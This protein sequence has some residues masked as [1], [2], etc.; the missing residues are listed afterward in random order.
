MIRRPSPL[1]NPTLALLACL[2]LMSVAWGSTVE[3]QIELPIPQ[4]IDVTGMRRVLVGGFRASDDPSVDVDIEYIDYTR[5]LLRKRSNFEVIDVDP[6]PLPEQEVKDI[7]NNR[8]YWR[9]LGKRYSADLIIAGILDFDRTDQSGFVQED[10]I[11]PITG[12][13]IRRTRYTEREGFNLASTLYFFSG[14][15]GELLYEQRLT[16][17][18]IFPG[19]NLDGLAVLHQLAARSSPEVLG[20]LMPRTKLETRYLFTE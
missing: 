8:S 11:S 10:I 4:K 6:P 20:V 3:V 9:R 16:E 15:T 5:D 13:R 18:A 7:I 12:Q 19:R 1:R 14:E 2:V 17:E